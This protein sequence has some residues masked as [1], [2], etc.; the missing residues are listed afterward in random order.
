MTL[1]WDEDWTWNNI[2]VEFWIWLP[3][4]W[5]LGVAR[6]PKLILNSAPGLRQNRDRFK[7]APVK[8]GLVAH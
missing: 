1:E 5:A 2:E 4:L 7:L 8:N 3:Q 6:N